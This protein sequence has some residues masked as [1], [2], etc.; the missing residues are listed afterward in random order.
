[1]AQL[2]VGWTADPKVAGSIPPCA[3]SKKAPTGLDVLEAL[4]VL[5]VGRIWDDSFGLQAHTL[6][7]A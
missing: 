3:K 7:V 5:T 4:G 2:G 6:W 1:M